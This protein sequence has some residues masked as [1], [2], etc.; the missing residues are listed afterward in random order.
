MR[1]T[2]ARLLLALAAL[3]GTLALTAHLTTQTVLNPDRAGTVARTLTGTQTGQRTLIT[4][5]ETTS[6]HRFSDV[7]RSQIAAALNDPKVTEALEE[8]RLERDG[9]VNLA[10][11]RDA[12]R[13]TLVDSGRPGLA[14]KLSTGGP[15]QVQLPAVL[16]D[17]YYALR[18][19]LQRFAHLGLLAALGL[20]G[21]SILISR[22]PARAMR[23]VG[24]VAIGAAAGSVVLFK[25]VP[26]ALR[27]AAGTDVVADAWS[28][29]GSDA[30]GASM[31]AATAGAA[32]IVAGSVLGLLSRPA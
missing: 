23:R 18:D 8:V 11:A 28:A 17:R 24:V 9:T 16:T 27:T 32:L 4:E 26:F 3:T 13:S 7:G 10:A 31:L 22:E 14:H 25:V 12:L 15:V 1:T 21:G 30:A 20:A 2:L 5:I 19:G 6:G 29:L